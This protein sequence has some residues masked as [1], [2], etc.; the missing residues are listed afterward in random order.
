MS[1]EGLWPQATHS[2]VVPELARE[3]VV[4]LG[5]A[6][7]GKSSLIRQFV[8]ATFDERYISTLG[9]NISKKSLLI[10]GPHGPIELVQTI[11]DVVGQ[12]D[13][14]TVQRFALKGA[15]GL[16]LV[17]DSTRHETFDHFDSWL[18]FLLE[19]V[20][21]IPTVLAANKWDLPNRELDAQELE[22]L[23]T[24][25]GVPYIL[26]SAKTGD[27]VEQAFRHLGTELL[28]D[29]KPNLDFFVEAPPRDVDPL[30][31]LEDRLI[32]TFCQMVGNLEVAMPIIRH[33]FKEVG[34]DFTKPKP[35]QLYE[36]LR[37]LVAAVEPFTGPDQASKIRQE[38]LKIVRR[39]LPR[40]VNPFE[41][42]PPRAAPH[43]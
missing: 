34:I 41:V 20:G 16:L 14:Q 33:K 18:R 19:A 39:A 7:V 22:G 25:M 42:Q 24:V 29:R 23:A 12:A 10:D 38:L 1:R 40:T 15:R 4:L 2:G 28:Y 37:R 43:L 8:H 3:K 30:L 11:W 32:S 13:F 5:D 36:V 17:C 26:T 21:P 35:E 27:G 31:D 9:T 6:S